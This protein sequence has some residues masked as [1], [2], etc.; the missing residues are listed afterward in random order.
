MPRFCPHDASGFIYEIS[1]MPAPLRADCI[2]S[3]A[4]FR[5]FDANAV[6]AGNIGSILV[7]NLLF[8]SAAAVFFLGMTAI[9]TRRRLE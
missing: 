1:S 2:L 8:L 7:P 9:K 3:R 4:L 5:G 6:Q